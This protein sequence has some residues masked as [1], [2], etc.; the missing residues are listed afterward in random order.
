MS[1]GSNVVT[2]ASIITPLKLDKFELFIFGIYA[3]L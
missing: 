3:F 1:N 2:Y